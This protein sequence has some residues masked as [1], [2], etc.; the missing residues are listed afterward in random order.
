[1]KAIIQK[2]TFGLGL[3]TV[4]VPVNAQDWPQFLGP[5]RNG[6]YDGPPLAT[7]WPN[8]APA[9]LW[10]RPIGAGFAGPVVADG[11]II[12]FHRVDGR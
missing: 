12:L 1:M 4:L 8:G 5:D 7:Q 9:E 3:I 11:R 2:I 6:Q 10:R